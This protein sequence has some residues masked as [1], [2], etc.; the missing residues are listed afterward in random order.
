MKTHSAVRNYFAVDCVCLAIKIGD[1]NLSPSEIINRVVIGSSHGILGVEVALLSLA[2]D[3]L[4][5]LLNKKILFDSLGPNTSIASKLDPML[6]RIPIG[7]NPLSYLRSL[8]SHNV[9]AYMR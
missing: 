3:L 4:L 9:S 5:L 2:E 6:Q 1:Q 7:Q 8:F